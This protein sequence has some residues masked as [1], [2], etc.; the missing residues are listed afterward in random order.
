[1]IGG[2]SRS[3]LGTITEIL[4]F[5]RPIYS[6]VGS[7]LTGAAHTFSFNDPSGMCLAC[8]G[9]GKNISVIFDKVIDMNLSLNDGAILFPA[10]AKDGWYWQIYES[11]EWFDMDLP[12]KD[13]PADLLDKLLYGES[14]KVQLVIH[15]KKPTNIE[16]EGVITKFRRLYIDRDLS[17]HSKRTREQVAEYTHL[18]TCQTC[19]GQRYNDK[20]LA[21]RINGKNIAEISELELNDLYTFVQSITEAS[22]LPLVEEVLKRVLQLIDMSLGYLT[23]ARE[24]ATL[25]GGESQ[26]IKMMKHL[27][28]SLT[29]FVYI[30]DE[31]SVGLHPYDVERLN[32]M[33][34]SLRDEGNTILVVEHDP[35][36]ILAADHIIDIGPKAGKH[37]GYVT[38]DGD[39]AGLLKSDTLTGR[40]LNILPELKVNP[41]LANDFF[42]LNNCSAN[43]LKNVSVNIPKGVLNV[44]SGVA[45]SGKS[46]L[47]HQEF[48][49]KYP[50][51]II[52][53]QKALHATS[54]SN[55]MTYTGIFDRIRTLFAK[56]NDVDKA[57]FSFNSKGGCPNCK[58]QGQVVTD[59]AYLEGVEIICSVCEGQRYIPEVLEYKYKGLNIV[60][61]L[62]LSVE[63]AKDFFEDKAI[64]KV[65]DALIKVGLAYISLGQSLDTLS[66]GECQ[67]VKLASELHKKG[68]VYILDEPTT[69][70]HMADI[71]AFMKIIDKLVDNDSTV[72]IIEHNVEMIK[73]ADWIID[74]GPKAGSGG[75]EIVYYGSLAGFKEIDSLTAD[76]IFKKR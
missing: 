21:C 5:L 44:I 33:L 37:G 17:A 65:I 69:G 8:D 23:L 1:Q 28:S 32:R 10:F 46:S 29:G 42:E 50:D 61:I 67:R 66:G 57:L 4:S 3:T 20:I 70:L 68:N 15:K 51:A 27:S 25:S 7:P 18:S 64:I 11:V 31:P 19:Q 73:Q 71:E 24:T 2:N 35:D 30:F 48:L 36:V 55:I 38:Y 14:E 40:Y 52:V 58:G 12:L 16:Y 56:A 72:I 53:D 63:D 39:L 6:R 26:R 74:L 75:G 13:Y 47:I 62:E 49:S 9:I 59:L 45:G 60:D 54:R 41:R 76:R 22:V 43:N 34:V